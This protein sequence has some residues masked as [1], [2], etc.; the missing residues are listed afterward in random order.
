MNKLNEIKWAGIIY[1]I[2]LDLFI[3]YPTLL[4]L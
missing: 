3:V 2:L 1:N 4:I